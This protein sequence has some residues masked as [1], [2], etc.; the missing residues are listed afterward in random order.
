MANKNR[1]EISIQAQGETVTL[2]IDFNALCALEEQGLDI[3]ALAAEMS[4]GK[5]IPMRKLLWAAMLRH[6]P[7]ATEA[8]AAAVAS[9][10]GLIETAQIFPRLFAAAGLVADGEAD[11]GNAP[12]LAKAPRQRRQTG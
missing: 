11:A 12:P 2:C 6:R 9:D 3:E 7:D 1:G 8:D 10:V 4:L 5:M